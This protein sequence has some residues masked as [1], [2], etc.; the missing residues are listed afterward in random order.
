MTL[1]KELLNIIVCPKC[2]GE[3]TYFEDRQCL[4]CD[5]C[6]LSFRVEDDI[7]ILLLEEA[8]SY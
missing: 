8:E 4:N 3:L 2:K 6:R 1:S 7:P 5:S